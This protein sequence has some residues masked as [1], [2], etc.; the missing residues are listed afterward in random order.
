VHGLLD[1][2]AGGGLAIAVLFEAQNLVTLLD[3]RA[4]LLCAGLGQS[5]NGIAQI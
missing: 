4:P 2:E 5:L 3:S 1:F